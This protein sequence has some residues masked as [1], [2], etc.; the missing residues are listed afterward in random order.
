MRGLPFSQ[1]C[2]NNREPIFERLQ[3]LLATCTKLLEIGSGTG[4]HGAYF[5]PFLP[6]L[7]WQYSDLEENHPS[8]EAWRQAAGCDNLLAP[9][10]LD[11]AKP[12]PLEQAVDVIYSANTLHIMSWAHVQALFA[13]MPQNLS[14]DGMCCIYGPFNYQGRY[15]SDSNANFDQWLKQRDPV[16]GIRD[17]EAVCTLAEQA[18]LALQDD[19]AMPANNRLLIFRRH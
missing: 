6:Q 17:F 19:H 10:V 9:I 18:G 2:E 11:A 1:A 14:A 12:W 8:I 15:I 4:Q 3:P 7:Q 16:S 5:A 13:Q